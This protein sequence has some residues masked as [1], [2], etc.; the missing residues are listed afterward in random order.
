MMA[1]AVQHSVSR[2]N[3]SA[4]NP[5]DLRDEAA[6]RRWRDAKLEGYPASARELIVEVADLARPSAAECTKITRCCRQANMA[7][8][9]SPPG[10]GGEQAAR[11]TLPQFTGFFGLTRLE[12]HRS[13]NEDG[14]VALEVAD[15]GT[16]RGYIPYSNRPL[17]WHTDG[18]YNAPEHM[19]RAMVLHCVR[20]AEEGGENALLDHEIAYIRLRDENPDLIAALMDPQAMTIPQ[21]REPS[22]KLRPASVGPVFSVDPR[23]GSLHMRYSARG[24][25]IAWR[26][27]RDTQAAVAFLT[28]MLSGSEPLI[29]RV[30]LAPGQGLICNNV[31]HCRSGFDKDG[32]LAQPS[33]RMLLR[34]RYF[35]RIAG[36]G[37]ADPARDPQHR[38]S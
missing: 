27:D 21:N 3:R 9:A 18:Y 11:R 26:Q 16:K 30:K 8:Y 1:T 23:T 15:E 12:S 2:Q 22:G 36:T 32:A 19:I 37:P 25:N 17:T 24:R 5:F 38:A 20:D 13:A 28:D 31:L 29:F 10:E 35:D 6:Y 14:I 33:K 7:V 34:M 4:G